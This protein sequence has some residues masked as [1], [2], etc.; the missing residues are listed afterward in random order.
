MPTN[1]DF[2]IRFTSET[3]INHFKQLPLHAT[4]NS[5]DKSIK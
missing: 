4:S 3:K 2:T 5:M 1:P